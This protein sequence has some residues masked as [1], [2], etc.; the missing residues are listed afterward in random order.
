MA[1]AIRSEWSANVALDATAREREALQT[2]PALQS[3]R[4]LHVAKRRRERR[5]EAFARVATWALIAGGL[6]VLFILA[7][8]GF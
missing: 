7:T 4:L 2:F 6:P 3:V 1:R 5:R 8:G